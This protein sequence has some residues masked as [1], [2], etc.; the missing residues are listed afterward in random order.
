M[1]EIWKPKNNFP[2]AALDLLSSH[3]SGLRAEALRHHNEIAANDADP[4]TSWRFLTNG[5]GESKLCLT[6]GS[7]DHPRTMSKRCA[8]TRDLSVVSRFIQNCQKPTLGSFSLGT[9]CWTRTQPGSLRTRLCP[10]FVEPL[11]DLVIAIFPIQWQ[12]VA[13]MF[14]NKQR[15]NFTVFL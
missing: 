12:R 3:T 4:F 15:I 6:S 1:V 5:A 13:V 10:E 9:A 14:V 8:V 2:I 7:S 11:N